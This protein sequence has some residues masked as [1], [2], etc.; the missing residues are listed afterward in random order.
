MVFYGKRQHPAFRYRC[1]KMD[2]F[3]GEA[4]EYLS[5][6]KIEEQS[7]SE[8]QYPI[9]FLNSLTIGNL[10][11]HKLILK[12]GS[13]II[14][15]RNIHLSDSLCNETKLVYRFFQKYIIE[16]EIIARKHAGTCAFIPHISLSPSN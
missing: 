12:S 3:P 10:P 2:Q 9:E 4:V 6:D 5:A 13:S 8:H 11:P 7:E 1:T 16:V 14:L 15:L